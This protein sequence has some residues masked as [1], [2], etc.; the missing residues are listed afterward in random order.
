MTTN[1]QL[2]GHAKRFPGGGGVVFT[3]ENGK[4]IDIDISPGARVSERQGRAVQRSW[5]AFVGALL[6]LGSDI[7]FRAQEPFV[8]HAWIYVSAMAR[9]IA[10]SQAPF[11]VWRETPDQV[12]RRAA[13]MKQTKVGWTGPKAG[14]RRRA[15]QRHLTRS[16]N[17]MR[18]CGARFKLLEPDFDH[19]LSDL[20]V[21][22]N[23]QMT[24]NQLWQVTEL[25]MA[26]RNA[27]FWLKLGPNGMRIG[28]NEQPTELW[29]VLPDAFRPEKKNGR[30]I[31]WRYRATASDPSMLASGT[32]VMLGLWEVVHF[33]V[34]NPADHCD[35]IS[36]MQP[37]APT[38]EYDLLAGQHNRSLMRNRA[39]PGGVFV[40]ET[41]RELWPLEEQASFMEQWR[42]QHAGT[43]NVGKQ[44]ILPSG[45]KY[46]QTALTN[47]DMQFIEGLREHRDEIFA[48]GRTP[49][50]VHGITDAVPYAVQAG[51]DKNFIDKTVV[52]QWLMY[53]LTLDATLFNEQTD[54]VVGAFDLS[55]VEALRIGLADRITNAK[56][57]CG[58]ELH[59][60]PRLA[61]EIAGIDDVPEYEG[62]DISLVGFNSMPLSTVLNPPDDTI[63]EEVPVEDPAAIDDES[64]KRFNIRSKRTN[65]DRKSRYWNAA[66]RVLLVPIERRHVRVWRDWIRVERENQLRRFDQ[67]VRARRSLTKQDEHFDID[68][69]LTPLDEMKQ[70]LGAGARAIYGPA[71]Q[72]VYQFTAETDLGGIPLFEI[73]DPAF[74]EFIESHRTR[75][76]GTAPRTIQQNVRRSLLQGQRFGETVQ[77]LRDR[78]GEVYDISASSSKAL[79]VARTETGSF[80]NGARSVMFEKQGFE[81]HEWVTANDEHVRDS[82]VVYGR[83]G[84]KPI[85]F[86]FMDLIGGGGILERPHDPR[87]PAREVV[88]CRCLVGPAL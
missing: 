12:S 74:G 3:D 47:Q 13:R 27:C 79:Q 37:L 20:F 85:G 7:T 78:V 43:E 5:N 72:S 88:N 11:M 61:F 1:Y 9:A 69:I 51:Q 36:P 18:F 71:L 15:I 29:P 40:D 66:H 62:D 53:E 33:N 42:D 31:A 84:A 55:G 63:E 56:S 57:L 22:P 34:P 82:H 68:A 45:L 67:A 25:I 46:V 32:E 19:E 30:L 64:D 58:T 8:N 73:D 2:N 49:K 6:G 28:P 80:V 41:T 44:I 86:N 60:P 77:E 76:V 59:M 4:P 48:V 65:E 24:A 16:A 35:A 54:D 10:I 70:H 75:L 39:D 17:P 87:A 81:K 38:I 14:V 83:A 50:T 52:P 21:R 23:P 26:L